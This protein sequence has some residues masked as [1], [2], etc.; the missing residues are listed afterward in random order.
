MLAR[1]GFIS[2]DHDSTGMI[3]VLRL[4]DGSRVL[5][6]EDL[7][8]SNGPLLK[9][10]LSDTA[11]I[12]GVAGWRD[13]DDSRHVD[14]GGLKGNIGSSY[15]PI[16]ADVDLAALPSVSI[17]C[18]RFD[19]SFVAATLHPVTQATR[20]PPERGPRAWRTR[21]RRLAQAAAARSS[22]PS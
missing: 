7:R 20:T 21:C 16:P 4:P 11:V 19:V 1:G 18:D 17:W 2:H 15:Y 5:R 3:S 9:V 13:F 10:W 22:A 6:L 14:L 8:T 12:E